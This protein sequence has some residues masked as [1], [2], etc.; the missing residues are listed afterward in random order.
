M[1]LASE[2]RQSDGCSWVHRATK[3]WDRPDGTGLLNIG[4]HKLVPTTF[5]SCEFQKCSIVDFVAYAMIQVVNELQQYILE[6]KLKKSM[7]VVAYC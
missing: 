6:L 7:T 1:N 5:G 4:P 2:R 3:T